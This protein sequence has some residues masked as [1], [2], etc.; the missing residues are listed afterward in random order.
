MKDDQ[1]DDM[2]RKK[3][4]E[5][6]SDVPADMWQRIS[7]R[8]GRRKKP[9]V[10]FWISLF[11]ILVL[12]VTIGY[13]DLFVHSAKNVINPN[14]GQLTTKPNSPVANNGTEDKVPAQDTMLQSSRPI[15]TTNNRFRKSFS[16]PESD[17]T[18]A[19]FKRKNDK[20]ID[21][22]HT[23]V[24]PSMKASN[25]QSEAES[26]T[27][28]DHKSD[29]ASA[30]S[31]D[32]TSDKTTSKAD[33]TTSSQ[34][35]KTSENETYDKFSIEIFGSPFYPVNSIHSSDTYAQLLKNS[36][37]MRLSAAAGIRFRYAISKRISATL[38][39]TYSNVNEK[40]MFTN[41]I[42]G[43]QYHGSNHYQFLDIPLLV[44]YNLPLSNSFTTAVTTGIVVNVSSKF[45]GA[46]PSASGEP[47]DISNANVYY[48]NRGAGWYFS[49]DFSK[50]IGNNIY[51]FAEP[52]FQA[53]LKN[54]T[55]TF[56]TFKQ[57]IHSAGVNIGAG[58]HF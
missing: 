49:V 46:I 35:K 43:Q 48:A 41:S 10:I 4:S 11:A 3:L 54:M 52:F 28:T 16:H 8:K 58:Y 23:N 13:K 32:K 26:S 29:S 33:S 12:L 19:S 31:P 24:R 45:K 2:M 1:F 15:L 50:N 17:K 39:L 6:A 34:N 20:S 5:F 30:T 7:N 9:V 36:A 37:T 27:N 42:N 57:K 14:V 40:V 44:S 25:D 55:N 53:S 38:G 21:H 56:Q 22:Y 51:F 47:V 18:V